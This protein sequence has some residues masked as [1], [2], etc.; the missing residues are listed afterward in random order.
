MG[1]QIIFGIILAG[2]MY[3]LPESPRY[4]IKVNKHDEAYA[5]LGFLHGLAVDHPVVTQEFHEILSNLEYEQLQ[6]KASYLG[7]WKRPFLKRQITGCALQ[8]LQQLSGSECQ[9]RLVLVPAHILQ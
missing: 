9:R 7:C 4:L 8:A 5:S 6:G 3:F 1:I 2:G